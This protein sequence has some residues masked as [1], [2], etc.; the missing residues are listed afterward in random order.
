MVNRGLTEAVYKTALVNQL[1]VA[2]DIKKPP[3]YTL[4]VT[5]A[6]CRPPWLTD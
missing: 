5:V 2:D 3:K 4:T 1:T 6:L